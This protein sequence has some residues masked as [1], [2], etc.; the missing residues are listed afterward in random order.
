MLMSTYVMSPNLFHLEKKCYYR[1]TIT[2]I[3]MP[4]SIRQSSIRVFTHNQVKYNGC[5]CTK[6]KTREIKGKGERERGGERD[7]ETDSER[8]RER[9]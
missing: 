2:F 7:R 5:D 4:T 9:E 1:K 3:Y 8:E 6:R